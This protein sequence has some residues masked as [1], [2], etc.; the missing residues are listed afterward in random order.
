MPDPSPTSA[1]AQGWAA[2]TG[3]ERLEQSAAAMS[4][5][6]RPWYEAVA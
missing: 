1:A 4:G 5:R 3:G 2:T 6:A